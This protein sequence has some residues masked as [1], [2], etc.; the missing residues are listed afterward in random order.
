MIP[1]LSYYHYESTPEKKVELHSLYSL[2][3]TR[4][5]GRG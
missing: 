1:P 4:P 5:T 2:S 3:L